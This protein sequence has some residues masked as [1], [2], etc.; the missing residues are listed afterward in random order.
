MSHEQQ[1]ILQCAAGDT[2]FALGCG[3]LFEGT[4][5]QMWHSLSKLLDIPAS[6]RVCCGHEYTQGNAKFAIHFDPD[7]KALQERK[8][9]I[10]SLRSQVQPLP[11]AG[12]L[13]CSHELVILDAHVSKPLHICNVM[14]QAAAAGH[15]LSRRDYF[16]GG[17]A[18][19][20]HVF[21]TP[22]TT[23]SEGDGVGT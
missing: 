18:K 20:H 3:R 13:W 22:S 10:D 23:C 4:A 7:N 5:A 14:K 21:L 12:M 19:R 16:N 15:G 11:A 6:T 17:F 8:A 1:R 2:L 9:S